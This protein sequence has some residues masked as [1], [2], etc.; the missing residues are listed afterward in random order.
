MGSLGAI[1]ASGASTYCGAGDQR[2]VG[3]W[4]SGLPRP[5]TRR[6][7]CAMLFIWPLCIPPPFRDRYGIRNAT[8]VLFEKLARSSSVR[9]LARSRVPGRG[10]GL[11]HR[12]A[13]AGCMASAALA[14]YEVAA[15]LTD[16][17]N[18][19]RLEHKLGEV[20]RRRGEWDLAES[21]FEAARPAPGGDGS[22]GERARLYADWSLVAHRRS[23]AAQAEDLAQEALRLAERRWSSPRRPWP[24]VCR[25]A[26]ASTKRAAQQPRRPTARG[27]P[28]RCRDR[29]PEAG[30]TYLR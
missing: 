14:S 6:Q 9:S 17:A 10:A 18:L 25:R 1:S 30:R 22:L 11:S 2:L 26:T 3:D 16:S 19:L 20:Y 15:A 27:W 23:H 8:R 28:P 29:S 7:F 24:C 4:T 12:P 5:S 13:C 21:H